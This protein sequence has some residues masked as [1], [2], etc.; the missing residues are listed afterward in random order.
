M[1]FEKDFKEEIFKINDETFVDSSLEV[2]NY[3]Y[4]NCSI[5]NDYCN[6]LKKTPREVKR[7]IDIPFLPI[8][9][10]KNHAIKSGTWQE[11]K[12]FKSSGT[13]GSSRSKHFVKDLSFYHRLAHQI[14]ESRFG[15]IDDLGII[16]VLPSYLEQGDSSLISMVDYFIQQSHAN[17]GYFTTEEV[18]DVIKSNHSKIVIGV[19]FALL[20]SIEKG[21]ETQNI[22]VMETGGM[23]GRRKEMTRYELHEKLKEGFNVSEVW[24]E[25]GMTELLSQAYGL[26]GFFEFPSWAK[27][28]IRDVNDPFSFLGEKKTGGINIIDL[29]NV[30]SCS[31]IET[32]DLGRQ[33]NGKFEVLG[34]FDNSDIRGCNL[35]I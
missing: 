8:E 17:S 10:F 26:N 13:T 32:K 20:D 5:Y 27:C 12:I 25:Y 29:A 16:A 3:Q 35:M 7:L 1:S 22:K 14:F 4:Y 24:S 33:Q 28:I 15:P 21:L 23:K 19:S 31:F 9:F 34:R 6:Y 11:E 2:F 18:K 30:D